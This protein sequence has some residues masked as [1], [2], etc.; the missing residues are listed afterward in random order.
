MISSYNMFSDEYLANGTRVIY[1]YVNI[2]LNL[3]SGLN[4]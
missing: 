3:I 4:N 2:G 1:R